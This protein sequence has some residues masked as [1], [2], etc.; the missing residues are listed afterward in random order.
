MGGR[1]VGGLASTLAAHMDF[2]PEN[3]ERV[4]RFWNAPGI[5]C[6][7]GRKAVDL[8]EAVGDGRIKALWVMATNPAVSMPDA[9][10]V[11]EALA[12][13]PFVVVSDV[14]ART[15]TLEFAH[16]KLPALAWGEKDG[17]VTNSERRISRQRAFLSPPGK[18]R[19]DW[20]I[21]AE[22]ARRMGHGAAFDFAG[23]AAIFRE[24]AALTAFEND[25]ARRLDLGALAGLS[26][27][28]YE[29]LAPYRWGGE[30]IALR[31]REARLT[32]V[33]QPPLVPGMVVNSGRY[34]DQWHSMTRTALSPRLSQHRRE[35]LVEVHPMDAAAAGLA[36]GDLARV[37]SAHGESLFKVAIAATPRGAA[38]S[39]RRCT[40]PTA[41][42]AAAARDCFQDRRW[43]RCRGSRDSS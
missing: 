19:P 18:A 28:D 27:E 42:P 29:G 35:P 17:T 10:Q 24:H 36:A 20:W 25:G 5:A 15:D 16:V 39:T 11:R 14:A 13:C 41:S 12:G 23:P 34:R 32:T 30:R 37:T 7:P 38:R 3:V 6:A 4:G 22:V 26:D 40:G 43:T 33:V 8:F 2:T 21:V 9:T 1:E 31:P